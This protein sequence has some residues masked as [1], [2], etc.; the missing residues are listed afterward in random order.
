MP[1]EGQKHDP[2]K[3]DSRD[4]VQGS[5]AAADSHAYGPGVT[6]MKI[7]GSIID[8][9]SP[10]T[11]RS[12]GRF[13]GDLSYNTSMACPLYRTQKCGRSPMACQG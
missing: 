11:G 3:S 5:A 12:P 9:Y 2:D 7:I 1:G 10:M 8:D 4:H 13:T 6:L